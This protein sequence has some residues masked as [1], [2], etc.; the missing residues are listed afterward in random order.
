M[1]NQADFHY[2]DN[3]GDNEQNLSW[4]MNGE[5]VRK[6]KRKHLILKKKEPKTGFMNVNDTL[7]SRFSS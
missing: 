4:Q 5:R 2:Q 6:K 3:Q 1:E 7:S